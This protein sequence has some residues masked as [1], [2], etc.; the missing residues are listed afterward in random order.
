M[1]AVILIGDDITGA[2]SNINMCVAGAVEC[3]KKDVK[4]S[5]NTDRHGWYNAQ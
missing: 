4:D 2:Q 5:G 1:H 3:M